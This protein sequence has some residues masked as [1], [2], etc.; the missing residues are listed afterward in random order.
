MSEQNVAM[1]RAMFAANEQFAGEKAALLD[2]LPGLMAQ[3]CTEDIEWREAPE[4]VDSRTRHGHD[5][6]VESFRTWLAGWDEYETDLKDA[7]DH[8]DCVLAKVHESGRAGGSG[9]QVDG[10]IYVVVTFRDGKVCR[11]EEFYDED[12]ARRAAS[13]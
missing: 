6:V 5:E 9:A 8:G 7:E 4:R 1:V 12:A 2:A 10:M 11:Y 13:A 3:V